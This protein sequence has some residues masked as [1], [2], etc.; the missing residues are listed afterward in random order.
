LRVLVSLMGEDLTSRAERL[1]LV[2]LL[3]VF[4]FNGDTLPGR[5]LRVAVA[6][7]ALLPGIA[8]I[9]R[10]ARDAV[11]HAAL[12]W[13]L[14]GLVTSSLIGIWLILAAACLPALERHTPPLRGGRGP[15][16]HSG[17]G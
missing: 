8:G 14:L 9:R 5:L 11:E 3:A 1:G 6:A 17:L 12:S 2:T 7:V 16:W 15:G 4:F 10:N 13:L